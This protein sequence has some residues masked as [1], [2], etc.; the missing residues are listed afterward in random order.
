MDEFSFCGSGEYKRLE[1]E[2]MTERL[3]RNQ[4]LRAIQDEVRPPHPG[5]FLREQFLLEFDQLSFGVGKLARKL[6]VSRKTV[7]MIV[8]EKAGITPEMAIRMNIALGEDPKV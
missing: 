2:M 3:K 4:E 1:A 6:A 7:S 5:R 8:H